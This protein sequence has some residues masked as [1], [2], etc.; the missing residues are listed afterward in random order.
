VS[1]CDNPT[2]P[3][4]KVILATSQ[5]ERRGAPFKMGLLHLIRS[6][7]STPR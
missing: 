1:D 4:Q 3:R 7:G 2:V 6:V 5:I